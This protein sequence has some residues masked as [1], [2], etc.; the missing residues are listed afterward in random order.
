NLAEFRPTRL[1]EGDFEVTAAADVPLAFIKIL[2]GIGETQRVSVSAV[3]R[4]TNISPV[5]RAPRLTSLDGDAHDFN[6]VWL[7]CFWPDRPENNDNLPRRTQMVP[8]ADN[9]GSKFE[10]DP[11]YPDYAKNP[12][13]DGDLR[14]EYLDRTQQGMRADLLDTAKDG[15]WYRDN[16]QGNKRSYVYL[17]PQCPLGSHLSLRLENVTSALYNVLHHGWSRNI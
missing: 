11:G 14:E 17:M 4:L 1:S 8:I 6:R 13:I 10:A 15:I 16:D 3:A 7:Y 2:P 5:F 9:A 12:I